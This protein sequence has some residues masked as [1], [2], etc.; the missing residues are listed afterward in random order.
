MKEY[1][2]HPTLG[3]IVIITENK[4]YT[5]KKKWSTNITL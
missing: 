1:F 2:I 3:K 5:T 4:H